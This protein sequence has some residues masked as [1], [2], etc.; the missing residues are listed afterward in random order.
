LG[1]HVRFEDAVARLGPAG[2]VKALK[3]DRFLA[4]L[5]EHPDIERIRDMCCDRTGWNDKRTASVLT[6]LNGEHISEK[7]IKSWRERNHA[8]VR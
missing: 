4:E 2:D 6:T 8:V 3:V 7:A 5:A 1:T